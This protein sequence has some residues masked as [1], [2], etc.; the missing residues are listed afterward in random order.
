MDYAELADEFLVHMQMF[1]KFEP[2][3][4][5]NESMRGEVFALHHI[6]ANGGDNIIP[7]E[8]SDAVGIS[9]ARIAATLNSLEKKGYIT[10]QID[11][12]DRRRILVTLTDTGREQEETYRRALVDSVERMLRLLGERDAKEY[13]RISRKLAKLAASEATLQEQDA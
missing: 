13:V 2:Q 1:R 11:P 3:Q 4:K 5:I 6:A 8:L 7:S 10:R 12:E 9:G